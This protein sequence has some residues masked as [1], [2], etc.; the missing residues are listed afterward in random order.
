[1]ID[2]VLDRTG[3]KDYLDDG[4]EE[5]EERWGVCNLEQPQN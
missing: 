1:L 4:T 5:G 3:Y 2:L